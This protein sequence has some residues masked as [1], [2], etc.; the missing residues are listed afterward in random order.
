MSMSDSLKSRSARRSP[1]LPPL[2][3]A[4][5]VGR[6]ALSEVAAEVAK[7]L[8]D[9]AEHRSL[10]AILGRAFLAVAERRPGLNERSGETLT[11]LASGAADALVPADDTESGAN[12]VSRLVAAERDYSRES[13]ADVFVTL[14]VSL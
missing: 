13:I 12:L 10:L 8:R 14:A 9:K 4:L 3:D 2:S 7:S 6:S 11:I 1:A 5:G